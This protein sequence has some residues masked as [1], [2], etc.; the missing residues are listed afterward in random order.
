VPDLDGLYRQRF[1][2]ADAER[3]LRLW[4]PIARYLERWICESD[5]VLDV[6]CDRGYFIRNCRSR[7]RWAIDLRDVR[8]DLSAGVTFVQRDSLELSAHVPNGH[9]DIVFMSNYLEHLGSAEEVVQQLRE[10][11]IVLK[12]AGRLI[13]LQPNIRFVGA[14]Y[15]DFLDHR[16]ALTDRSLAEA[17]RLAGF[18][19]ESLRP[20][21][22]PYSTK[23]SLPQHPLLI[24]A[25]LAFAPAWRLLGKQT[26][27]VAKRTA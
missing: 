17:A 27:L 11:A 10:A 16:V 4:R 15:W 3:K 18:E 1:T 5:A 9:F 7:E 8:A 6:A 25:F 19:I 23:S 14:A 21:F 24:R 20:R 13:V 12:P 22:L 2:D 26:L